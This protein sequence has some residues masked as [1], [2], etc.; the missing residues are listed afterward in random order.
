MLVFNPHLRDTV[1]QLKNDGWHN[2]LIQKYI[3]Y[4][5]AK[6]RRIKTGRTAV[7]D[8][9]RSKTYKAEWKFQAKYKYE[10]QDFDTLKEAQRYMNRV[11]KSKLW[12]ELCGGDPKIPTLE[13]NGFRG[14]TAGRAYGWKIQ[15]CA[16]NGMDQY[17]L[18]H[19][20]A[21]CAGHMHHDVSFRQCLLKLVSRFIGKDAAKCLKEC[22]KEQGLK[23]SVGKTIQTPEKWLQGY[24]RLEAAREK[25]AA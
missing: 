6:N 8:S 10:I 21:H 5:D 15:L 13:V 9:G 24:K 12:A 7:T 25:C 18:L 23:M 20:M 2:E 16:R 22:F 3:N 14:R 11:L 4:A 1:N 19:E 17:T